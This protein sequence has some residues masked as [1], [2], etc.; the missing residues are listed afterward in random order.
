MTYFCKNRSELLAAIRTSVPGD[1]I[2]LPA[3]TR[4]GSEA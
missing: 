4:F 1:V 3:N 2:H